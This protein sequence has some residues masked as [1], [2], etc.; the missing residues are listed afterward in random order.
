MTFFEL[1][2][3]E[4]VKKFSSMMNFSHSS[5]ESENSRKNE[6]HSKEMSVGTLAHTQFKLQESQRSKNKQTCTILKLF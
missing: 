5:R 2:S 4:K 1:V 3:P 6:S